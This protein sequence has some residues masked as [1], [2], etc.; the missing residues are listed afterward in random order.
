MYEE[1]SLFTPDMMNLE[2]MFLENQ[3]MNL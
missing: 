3:E 2:R 1:E